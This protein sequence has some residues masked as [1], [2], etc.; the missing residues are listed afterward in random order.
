L[1]RQKLFPL[2]S[3]TSPTF[4]FSLNSTIFPLWHRKKQQEIEEQQLSPERQLLLFVSKIINR[5]PLFH[6]LL[7]TTAERSIE[8]MENQKNQTTEELPFLLDVQTIQDKILPLS[9]KKIRQILQNGYL[10]TL[11]IGGRLY[12]EKTAFL[13]YISDPDIEKIP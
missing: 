12:V 7:G 8:N 3:P 5:V 6:S 13:N 4:F 1:L 10:R 2:F 11:K 9:K